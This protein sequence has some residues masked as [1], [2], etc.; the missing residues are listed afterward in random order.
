MSSGYGRGKGQS[1]P[2]ADNTLYGYATAYENLYS[3]QMV[4]NNK[5]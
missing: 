1:D 4:E 5:N 2:G 3:P